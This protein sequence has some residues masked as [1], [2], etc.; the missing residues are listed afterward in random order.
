MNFKLLVNQIKT[1]PYYSSG[2]DAFI[3]V[4]SPTKLLM[5]IVEGSTLKKGIV[6]PDVPLDARVTNLRVPAGHWLLLA[7]AEA[8]NEIE[9]GLRRTSD[10][11]GV[12]T[13]PL[14]LVKSEPL[15]VAQGTT[16]V[17]A[18][19]GLNRASVYRLIVHSNM[20]EN[21]GSFQVQSGTDTIHPLSGAFILDASVPSGG[22]LEIHVL[23]GNY[24]GFYDL[25]V[26][27]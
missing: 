20:L 23:N 16:F 1:S 22:R 5:M 18:R 10:G 11:Q 26:D 2:S 8:Q 9:L 21:N 27:P 4:V 24:V 19:N 25:F 12:L 3:E 7:R 17:L 14:Q 15:D 6:V 13:A